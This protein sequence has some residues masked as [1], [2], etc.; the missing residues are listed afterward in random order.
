MKIIVCGMQKRRFNR[1]R[2]CRRKLKSNKS[3]S[4]SSPGKDQ[5]V[6]AHGIND[7]LSADKL[8]I[9]SPHTPAPLTPARPSK[10]LPGDPWGSARPGHRLIMPTPPRGSPKA[11]PPA[12]LASHPKLPPSRDILVLYHLYTRR[13]MLNSSSPTG[14]QV[15]SQ[16]ATLPEHT[17][18]W[19]L[20]FR[21]RLHLLRSKGDWGG[22]LTVGT[23][24][25]SI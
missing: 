20:R 12:G 21:R 25:F 11:P 16:Q 22:I 2:R 24:K 6:E 14:D 18:A 23:D 10:G 8:A 9:R 13:K 7:T 19:T 1:S 15:L 17:A 4:T 5:A 3:S